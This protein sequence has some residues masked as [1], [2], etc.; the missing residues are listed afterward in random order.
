MMPTI[1]EYSAVNICNLALNQLSEQEI[2]GLTETSKP[3]RLCKRYFEQS[4]DELLRAYDWNF[5]SS[6]VVLAQLSEEPLFGW[7]FAYA[8]PTDFLMI[9]NKE[10]YGSYRIEDG[11]LLSNKDTTEFNIRYTR[12]ID[13][14]NDCDALFIECWYLYLAYKIAFPLTGDR[15]LR[16]E[17]LQ[18]YKDALIRAKQVDDIEDHPDA[19]PTP[20]TLVGRSQRTYGT[21]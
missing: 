19:D 11:K 13:D 15:T 3:A 10:T 20:W 16:G 1:P 18:Y 12:R 5:A 6:R 9:R 2:G 8:L 14:Y 21:Y 7:D 4:R 17:M